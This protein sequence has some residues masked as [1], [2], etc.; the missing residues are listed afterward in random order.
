MRSA[1]L[2]IIVL[3]YHSILA[4]V[5]HIPLK[6]PDGNMRHLNMGKSYTVLVFL[7]PECPLCQ[8]YTLTLNQLS[9]TYG[10]DALRFY[11]IIS[12]K[13]FTAQSVK[14]F[15]KKYKIHFPLWM[16][17]E[18]SL[19]G[20]FKALVTPEVVVVNT[21]EQIEYQGRID[22]W[23]YEVG[24]K[25][26]LITQHDLKNALEALKKGNAVMIKRTKAIGCFIE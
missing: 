17:I 6:D 14:S 20:R 1:L 25:R 26:K 9:A 15:Q 16:D 24:R 23:A 18:K 10:S 5:S 13:N 4:Q 8:N 21:K 3:L 11:G 12:G 19:A 7:S 22:N 2:V